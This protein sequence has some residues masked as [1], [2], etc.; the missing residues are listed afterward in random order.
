MSR[1]KDIER[2]IALKAQN[3]GYGGFRGYN[4]AETGQSQSLQAMTCTVCGRRRN[5]PVDVAQEQ[6]E[7]YICLSCREEEQGTEPEAEVA[8]PAG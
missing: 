1:R 3:P 5:V 4:Q 6:T 8:E 7:G 2:Y